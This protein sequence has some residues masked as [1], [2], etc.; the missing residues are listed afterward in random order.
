MNGLN[1]NNK[2]YESILVPFMF[3]LKRLLFAP[4]ILFLSDT[5]FASLMTLTFIE[6][7]YIGVMLWN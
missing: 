3:Y 4:A 1:T 2:K 6:Q 5:P 7:I